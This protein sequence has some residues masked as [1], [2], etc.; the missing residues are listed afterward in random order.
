MSGKPHAAAQPLSLSVRRER[1]QARERRIDYLARAY[2]CRDTAARTLD[3]HDA[4]FLRAM[5]IVWRLL[6]DKGAGMPNAAR[7][8][9]GDGLPSGLIG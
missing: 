6:A 1:V 5:T 8:S 9:G 3:A 4:Q 7:Y 2:A